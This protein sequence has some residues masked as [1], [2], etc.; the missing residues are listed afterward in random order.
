MKSPLEQFDIINIKNINIFGNDYSINNISIPIICILL[1]C[2]VYI[3]IYRYKYNFLGS[4]ITSF[5]EHIY[6]F[7]NNLIKQQA[8]N[9]GLF[10]FPLIFCIFNFILFSNLISLIPFGIALTSHF[11]LIFWLSCTICTS[12]F[13]IGLIRFN[14]KFLY[15]FIPKCPFIILP[16]LIPIEIFSYLIRLLSLALRLA[17]N[18]VAGH[19]LVHVLINFI[20]N[21]LK[22]DY[23]LSLFII[24]PLMIILVLELG[25][26]FLQAYIFTVLIC[27]YLADTEKGALH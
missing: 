25:I 5:L 15:I 6:I 26:A 4:Y 10:W 14:L 2:I 12:I 3:F 1:V 20:L 24:I 23:I 9:Y 22:I 13:L 17:A 11:I 16:I 21:I 27:I 19:T 18:L 8:G 7:I